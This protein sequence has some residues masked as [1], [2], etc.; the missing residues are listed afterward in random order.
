MDSNSTSYTPLQIAAAVALGP[1][2]EK[3][4]KF[5]ETK[6]KVSQQAAFGLTVQLTGKSHLFQVIP[7]F[8][9]PQNGAHSCCGLT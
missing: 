9:A 3:L 2:F 7:P 5:W 8:T 1:S 6:L 4:V